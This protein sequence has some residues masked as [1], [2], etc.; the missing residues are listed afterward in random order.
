[1]KN[2]YSDFAFGSQIDGV[3]TRVNSQ[4]GELVVIGSSRLAQHRQ[5]FLG[6]TANKVLRALPVPLVVVPRDYERVDTRPWP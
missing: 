4:V 6:A 2:T 1:M 3:V 5:L